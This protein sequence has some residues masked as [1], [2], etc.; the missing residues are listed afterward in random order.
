M[1]QMALRPK[2][3][4]KA[5]KIRNMTKQPA[6]SFSLG[7]FLNSL[8]PS[9][10]SQT[11]LYG[12]IE[13]RRRF[14]L[15]DIVKQRS[16]SFSLVFFVNW[17]C[18]SFWSQSHLSHRIWRLDQSKLRIWSN[19]RQIRFFKVFSWTRCALHFAPRCLCMVVSSFADRSIWTILSN[20]VQIRIL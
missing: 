1:R 19:N 16:D 8:C 11:P 3:R 4:L 7:F 14:K 10:C 15:N 9:F 2:W 13:L 17:I 12:R 5:V 18:P 20:Y 6:D